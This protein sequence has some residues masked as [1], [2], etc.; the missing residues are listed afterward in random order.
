MTDDDLDLVDTERL[1]DALMRRFAYG[2]IALGKEEKDT[3]MVILSQ[4]KGHPATAVGMAQLTIHDI[5]AEWLSNI[6]S[7]KS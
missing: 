3:T 4:W 7:E 5:S 1:S 2:V 6:S